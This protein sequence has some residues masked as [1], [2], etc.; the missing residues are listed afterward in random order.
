MEEVPVE[1]QICLEAGTG[2]GNM[3]CYLIERGARLVYSISNNQE[4]LDYAQ[5]RLSREDEKKVKFIN[6]DL[7]NL[8]FI[9]SGSIDL[10]TAHMLLNVVQPA[11]LF[12][13]FKEL[14]RVIKK[15]GYL[16]INDYNPLLSYQMDRTYLVEELFKLE[17]AVHQ[18]VN[19]KPALVWYSSD[20][21]SD[22]LQTLGWNI[23]STNLLFDKTPWSKQLLQEHVDEIEKI[24]NK[25]NDDVVKQNLLRM[26]KS[27]FNE[28]DDDE[29][30]YGG[31]VYSIK[32][33]RE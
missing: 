5:S 13:I 20:Y 11:E 3:T 16:I 17:N 2:A 15:D 10:T 31:S 25:I 28:I 30:I 9:S 32:M 27:V 29:I 4:H 19:D 26:A 22:L 18:L 7:Q 6:A 8:E 24:G 14:T 23:H 21:V 1:G 33:Q 12:L